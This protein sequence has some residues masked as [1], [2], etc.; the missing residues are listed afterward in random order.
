[1]AHPLQTRLGMGVVTII[2]FFVMLPVVAIAMGPFSF[3][4]WEWV[5][6][7]MVG[8]LGAGGLI[9]MLYLIEPE[10]LEQH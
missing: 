5:A 8:G 1:M 6:L 10:R 7:A 2:T 4:F 9:G 3:G